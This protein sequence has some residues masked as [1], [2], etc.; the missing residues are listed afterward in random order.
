M[1]VIHYRKFL[2]GSWFYEL[3][4][5]FVNSSHHKLHYQMVEARR[6]CGKV[7]L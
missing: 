4:H 6:G 2:A 5:I 7:A 1:H 3:K